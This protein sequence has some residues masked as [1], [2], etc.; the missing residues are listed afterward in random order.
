M[1]APRFCRIVTALC[2]LM[3]LGRAAEAAEPGAADLA[4]ELRGLDTRAFPV[5]RREA[6]RS[7]VAK[8]LSAQIKAVNTAN[9]AAWERLKTRDDW[10]K[11]R[12]ERLNALRASLDWKTERTRPALHVTG[13]LAG[14]GYRVRRLIYETRPRWFVTANLYLPAKTPQSM[15]GIILS[16]SH[17]NPKSQGE[18]QDMGMTWARG[19]C[20][21]LVP[22]HLGHGERRQHPFV[23]AN[24][25]DKPFAVG[26]Q[27]YYFRYD[28][29][30]QLHLVGESLLGW[31]VWDLM[32]G[33]DVL[34]MQE[35][36]DPKRII[37]LGSV[38]G[39][40]DPAAVTAALDE[41]IACVVPF[42]FGGPQPETR[43]PL[44]DDAATWFNYAGD[45]SWESTRNLTDSANGL[46]FQPWAI[47][48][49]VAPRRLIYG[50]EFSWDGERDPVWKRFEKIW[51][52]Y[53]A[54]DNLAVAHGKGTLQGQPP[55]ASHCNNIGAFHRRMIHP[56]FKRWFDIDV[57][58]ETEFSARLGESELNCWTDAARAELR[59]LSLHEVLSALAAERVTRFRTQQSNRDATERLAEL[60][61]LWRKVLRLQDAGEIATATV[62]EVRL[63]GLAA[64][65]VLLNDRV[66]LLLL[67]PAEPKPERVP[68]VV[69]VSQVGKETFLRN[70]ATEI[71]ALLRSNV[72][73]ALVDVRGTGETSLGTDRGQ[74]SSAT[75]HSSTALMLG[76]PLVGQQL[77]DLQLALAFLRTQSIVDRSRLGIW[78]ES[79]EP[80]LPADAQF[81]YP[82]RIDRPN[83][84]SPLGALLALLATLMEEDVDAVT[85]RGGL[86]SHASILSS[87]FVQIP[88][89]IVIP[90]ALDAGDLADLV[91]ALAPRAVRFEELVDGTN[92]RVPL[93]SL[94]KE[95]A[96]ARAAYG[97]TGAANR[98]T[99]RTEPSS[100]A[101]FF[102][103][104]LHADR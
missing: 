13:E 90:G 102:V 62:E 46:G 4:A 76:R 25:H 42:N 53:D 82:R 70:R 88:H 18:L 75:A 56:L 36:V 48:G 94:D 30:M 20:A 9:S 51:G 95:Y 68:L 73:V 98:F 83:E 61:R 103:R 78:G 10:E 87:P 85:V 86:I 97:Q 7:L 3:M 27:D 8:E 63:A 49:S 74:F 50:H 80:S 58:P 6:A 23:T 52:W 72:A 11:F 79:F 41:R 19:G 54:S 67:L 34:L 24:D 77:A 55:D 100:P 43:Y 47:V 45:G 91:A 69:G 57:T 71:A 101:E 59:P 1:R 2:A 104:Q 37:L 39:G 14:D 16:H 81:R 5:D 93:S 32:G 40:G 66:P 84:S 96:S 92:R 21:V 22:D 26:R 38:A 33:V 35:G 12:L 65:R 44:P 17:H 89:D 99:V 15:P 28:T 64:K 60:R 31:L 29:G